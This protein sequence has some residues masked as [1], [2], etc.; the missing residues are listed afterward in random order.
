[1]SLRASD[2]SDAD[3]S[4]RLRQR[5]LHRLVHGDRRRRTIPQIRRRDR[6]VPL[7][8]RA[9]AQHQALEA[10]LRFRQRL[11]R[12]GHGQFEARDLRLRLD[13][14]DRR[15]RARLD[16]TLV[17]RHLSARL[18]QRARLHFEVALGEHEVPVGLLDEGELLGDHAAQLRI[19][20]VDVLLR[21]QNLT[22]LLIDRPIAE[23]RLRETEVQERGKLRVQPAE[24][25]ARFEARLREVD[26]RTRRPDADCGPRAGCRRTVPS[27][28]RGPPWRRRARM[29]SRCSRARRRNSE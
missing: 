5:Q 20:E 1:M 28:S 27:A 16:L 17:A 25:V 6:A 18:R 23:Q 8:R 2:A 21:Q 29:R 10:V 7:R 3:S 15:E 13:H 4:G 26:R 9:V 22:P 19:G 14:V 12:G 24:L 11:L